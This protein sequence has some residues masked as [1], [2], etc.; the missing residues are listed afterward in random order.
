[1]ECICVCTR[2]VRRTVEF[3]K[4]RHAQLDRAH[5][6]LCKR[7][8]RVQHGR[9]LGWEVDRFALEQNKRPSADVLVVAEGS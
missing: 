7:P 6:M 1:M 9:V 4:G 2:Q 5:E 8:L 3:V